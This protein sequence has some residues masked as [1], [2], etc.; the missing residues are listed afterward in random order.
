[1]SALREPH[2]F[3]GAA[4]PSQSSVSE[5]A[6]N[7][8]R[9]NRQTSECEVQYIIYYGSKIAGL[10]VVCRSNCGKNCLANI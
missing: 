2:S 5:L 9:Y 10:A 3:F 7:E 6:E 4:L 1:V 8:V